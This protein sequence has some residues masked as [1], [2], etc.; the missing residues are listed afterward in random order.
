MFRKWLR[1]LRMLLLRKSSETFRYF[2]GKIDWVK[3]LDRTIDALK[4]LN[5]MQVSYFDFSYRNGKQP[6]AYSET[7]QA[8]RQSLIKKPCLSA[9]LRLFL[10]L[11]KLCLGV[12]LLLSPSLCSRHFQSRLAVYTHCTDWL[13]QKMTAIVPVPVD[14][15]A[16]QQRAS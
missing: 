5:A 12:F 9:C 4:L 14:W 1:I 10:R 16:T 13:E 6:A 8:K 3:S 15:K 2:G 7:A 11:C